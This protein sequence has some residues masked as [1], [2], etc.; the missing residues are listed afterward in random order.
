MTSGR[1]RGEHGRGWKNRGGTNH[2]GLGNMLH[3]SLCYDHIAVDMYAS[4]EPP[5]NHCTI[6]STRFVV[7]F[8]CD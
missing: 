7:A 2:V 3:F 4:Q 5:S 8:H 6:S 1:G